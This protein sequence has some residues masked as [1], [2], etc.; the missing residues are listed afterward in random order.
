MIVKGVPTF[1]ATIYVGFKNRDTKEVAN[2]NAVVAAVQ[3][4]VNTVGL[5]VTVTDTTFVYVNGK[6][7]GM[8]I[9]LSQL[10]TISFY[11]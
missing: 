10:S 1:T 7:P 8:A 5:C 6:E 11:T 9:G 4:Y 2:R 3:A